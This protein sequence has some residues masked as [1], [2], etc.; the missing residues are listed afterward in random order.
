MQRESFILAIGIDNYPGPHFGSLEN[1]SGDAKRFSEL[2]V[3]RYGFQEVMP[4]LLNEKATQENI[5]N[6]LDGLAFRIGK[7]D[8][9]IIYFAGH[10]GKNPTSDIGYW[11]PV[12][13][14]QKTFQRIQN[15]YVLDCIE[16]ITAKH[17]ILISDSCFSGTLLEKDRAGNPDL[18]HEY[19]DSLNSGWILVS[20][21]IEKVTDGEKGK[22]TP[23]NQTICEFL[24]KNTKPSVA[25]GEFFDEVI[26]ITRER[27]LQSP[28]VA[29]IKRGE[30]H[31]G[32]QMIFRLNETNRGSGISDISGG[33]TAF[34]K[35]V[36]ALPNTT[37]P[38]AYLPR[39]LTYYD[40][41]KPAI[42]WFYEPEVGELF[43]K[44][45]ITT[46]KR[47]VVLGSAGSG[48][49]IELQQLMKTLQEDTN[50]EFIPIYKKFN[51]YTDEDIADYLPQNWEQADK[52]ALVLFLDGLDEI[53]PKFFSTA[54][55]KLGAFSDRNPQIRIVVSSRTNFYELPDASFSGTLDGYAVYTLNDISLAQIKKYVADSHG[56]NGDEFIYAIYQRGYLDLVQKPYFLNILVNYFIKH[57]NF[58]SGRAA[59]LED[60][61]NQYE[62][63]NKQQYHSTDPPLKHKDLLPLQ[64]KIAFILERTGRNFIDDKELASVLT[65]DE[66]EA[67]KYLSAFKLEP[68]KAQWH[69]EH[70]NIQEYLASRV[71]SH[72]SFEGMMKVLTVSSAGEPKIKPNWVNTLSFLIS[73]GEKEKIKPLLDWLIA[74]DPE[75]L[76]RFDPDR[77]PK[78]NRIALFKDI[79]NFYSQKQVWLSSNKFSD[80][81][82]A[83][84]GHFEEVLI[85][86]LEILK[87]GKA[88]RIDVLNALHV[89]YRFDISKF[90]SYKEALK[91]I[92]ISLIKRPDFNSSD[93]YTVIGALSKLGIDDPETIEFLYQQY[94]QREN[95]YLRAAL[96]KIIGN[97]EVLDKYV[98][99]FTDGL[100]MNGFNYQSEDR[101]TVTLMDEGMQLKEGL[102][103]IKT[104][105]AIAELLTIVA[106][107]IN[108]VHRFFS[109]YKESMEKILAHV[110]DAYIEDK[111]L[112]KLIVQLY[113]RQATETNKPHIDQFLS[114]F[115]KN[116][117]RWE[118]TF[119]LLN[120]VSIRDYEKS[121]GIGALVNEHIIDNLI[122]QYS[123]GI[124]SKESLEKVYRDFKWRESGSGNFEDILSY[125]K[126]QLSQTDIEIQNEPEIDRAKLFRE[127]AQ[128]GFNLLFDKEGF[129]AEVNQIFDFF[130]KE[131]IIGEDLY[132]YK[133]GEYVDLSQRF[134]TSTVDLIRE[135]TYRGSVA[136][137]EHL[138][139][140]MNE[141]EEFTNFRIQL[142][143]SRL[144]AL[145]ELE[146]SQEQEQYIRN[147][148]QEKAPTGGLLWY[149]INRFK[150]ELPE[151]RLL[152][153][154]R[155]YNQSDEINIETG[156]FIELLEKFVKPDVLRKTVTENLNNGLQNILTWTSNAGYALR[157]DLTQ[158]FPLIL[159]QI[160][161]FNETEYKFAD[162][163][164]LWFSKTGDTK[165]LIKFVANTQS[166]DM[167]ERAIRLLRDSGEENDY[168][169]GYF[170][171]IADND[172]VSDEEKLDA[173][174]RL[175]KLG[176]I[177]GFYI[178]TN[179]FLSNPNPLFDFK[180]HFRNINYA[181]N[182]QVIPVLME[183]LYIGK[184]DDY[185]KDVFNDLETKVLEVLFEIG[186]QS[187]KSF[188]EVKSALE[189][190][191][192]VNQGKLANIN[193]L[194][195]T[196][197]RMQE[198]L[199]L[200]LS[201]ELTVE[202]ALQEFQLLGKSE[203]TVANQVNI[204]VKKLIINKRMKIEKVIAKKGSQ[205]NIADVIKKIE[206]NPVLNSATKNDF[207]QVKQ[208]L[209]QLDNDDLQEI[210]ANV[211]ALPAESSDLTIY[212]SVRV[213]LDNFAL[214]HGVPII[215]GIAATVLY[216][217][218]KSIFKI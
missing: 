36:F 168:L 95:Q 48:K 97:S 209:V 16:G 202:E 213:Q 79:F 25:A 68:D 185:K 172:S 28:G 24:E 61:I 146:V 206:F 57:G 27:T 23:F 26:R 13:E 141:S 89:L 161:G 150:I 195:F 198:Q 90:S 117:L 137:R 108:T 135:F 80:T 44:D 207:D 35:P 119:Y 193:F 182:P 29:P 189:E 11:V 102:E 67:A 155:Y 211:E 53:Q 143:K 139:H 45:I 184:Q 178:I 109:E 144:T 12:D 164:K 91:D 46:Q 180:R 72:L 157:N 124:I 83:R 92:L 158:S 112:F 152:T 22:G 37:L 110:F 203:A 87:D 126:Q 6:A 101:D 33:A 5:T 121:S 116:D 14:G 142:I 188:N 56:I 47:I 156:G 71:L 177:D 105:A 190:F 122:T 52:S 18:S 107:D 74:N 9:L 34:S 187:N 212:E 134:S 106:G 38:P 125:F 73:V 159:S 191:I 179:H 8:N 197:I 41:Q 196:I 43:L 3:S 103:K 84:F 138:N 1:A 39:T 115:D 140:W 173:A 118:T 149:F 85:F 174:N 86:L 21:G 215:D 153:F 78:E 81:D 162:L 17:I 77:V 51:T 7:E 113:A 201:K 192:A 166:P 40:I 111:S 99:V 130:E 151:E 217:V 19:L 210:Q 60:A 148:S 69:F 205:V 165:R 104:P 2:L 132:S 15:S 75:I 93:I 218:L 94:G 82:L 42:T 32:G 176:I 186:V 147:W 31:H 136:Q 123:K 128:K 194:H 49:S 62:T 169:I 200:K 65:A 10:G 204:N 20:G 175:L 120:E 129:I 63:A 100:R 160:E 59:I 133:S 216:E 76:V 167:K 127:A 171:S 50:S 145:P 163:L 30:I 114:F 199:S 55:R 96:Y 4:P 214:K 154:T 208:L 170:R 98:R 66:Y 54:L 88:T 58:D 64:E 70:N 181:S 131:E 183:L